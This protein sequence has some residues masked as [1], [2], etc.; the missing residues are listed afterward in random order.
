MNGNRAL[1]PLPREV[2][3][4][5]PLSDGQIR[6]DLIRLGDGIRGVAALDRVWPLLRIGGLLIGP[7][8][9]NAVLDR[10]ARDRASA[11]APLSLAGR[12]LHWVIEKRRA[13]D[14]V[15]ASAS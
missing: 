9:P 8:P 12:E 3:G 14:A 6:V 1:A 11:I 13:A 2:D 7:G 10:F 15:I 4:A 5:N